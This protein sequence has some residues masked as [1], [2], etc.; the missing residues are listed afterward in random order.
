MFRHVVMFRWKDDVDVAATDQ[1]LEELRR[2]PDLVESLRGF[3]V[4]QD[5]GVNEGNF[6]VVVVADFDDREGYLTYRDH[7][8]HVRVAR[9][10]LGPLIAERA[11]VQYDLDGGSS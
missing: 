8:E 1:P 3:S 5:A 10:H 7:P 6:D 4:G 11:A 2:L 9:D